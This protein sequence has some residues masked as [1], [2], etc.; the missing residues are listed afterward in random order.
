MIY[1]DNK[2]IQEHIHGT[3]NTDIR[4]A[5]YALESLKVYNSK[6]VKENK[7]LLEEA[8]LKASRLK[9]YLFYKF[10]NSISKMRNLVFEPANLIFYFQGHELFFLCR[11][12]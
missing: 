9:A 3:T 5:K 8:F 11:R 10:Q 1:E 2:A 7:A 6:T 4:K 12:T